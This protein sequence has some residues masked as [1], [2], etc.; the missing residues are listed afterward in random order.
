MV[1]RD[2]STVVEVGCVSSL[3]VVI[4]IVLR[5]SV[6]VV[7][8]RSPPSLGSDIVRYMDGSTVV[9]EGSK[10]LNEVY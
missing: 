8:I 4:S 10:T 7:G 6:A 1:V 5:I 3:V 2:G 9:E